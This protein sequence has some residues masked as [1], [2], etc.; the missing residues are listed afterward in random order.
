MQFLPH[1]APWLFLFCA[2]HCTLEKPPSS[3]H[4]GSA[5]WLLWKK[6]HTRQ[7][8]NATKKKLSSRRL[9]VRHDLLVHRSRVQRAGTFIYFTDGSTWLGTLTRHGG[10]RRTGACVPPGVSFAKGAKVFPGET[11]VGEV[12]CN[13]VLCFERFEFWACVSWCKYV[14][15]YRRTYIRDEF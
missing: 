2:G 15:M 14:T 5:A 1:G 4:R 10:G 6:L 9:F 3:I 11:S 12:P 13:Q 8:I 7:A